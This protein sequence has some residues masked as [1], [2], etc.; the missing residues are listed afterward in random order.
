MARTILESDALLSVHRST[1]ILRDAD[2]DAWSDG[3]AVAGDGVVTQFGY[4]IEVTALSA[5]PRAEVRVWDVAPEDSED[6]DSSDSSGGG[7][8]GVGD[9]ELPCPTGHFLVETLFVGPG[10]EAQL[11]GG[12]GVYGVR[13]AWRGRQRGRDAEDELYGA[14]RGAADEVLFAALDGVRGIEHYRVDLWRRADLPPD[15][16]D[17]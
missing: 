6:S 4:G 17:D 5:G 1:I 13:I 16:D 11:P 8:D 2:C 14:H 3:G 7:W 15:D 10:L 12:P 9:F